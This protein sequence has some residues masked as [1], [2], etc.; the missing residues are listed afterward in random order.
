[1]AKQTIKALVEGGKAT[2]APPLGPALG[3]AKLPLIKLI[4]EINNLTKSFA[5]MKVPISITYDTAT[6][7]YSIKVGTPPTSQLIKTELGIG[8]G[9]A[10]RKA[11]VGDLSLEKAVKIAKLKHASMLSK[12]LDS[13]VKEVLGT[14]VSMGVTVEGKDPRQIQKEIDEGK[15]SNLF[16]TTS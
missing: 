4:G 7:E 9:G 8:K 11:S 15:H 10:D 16:K 2:P 1:M 14:C 3:A 13:A 5:G 12:S 6:L